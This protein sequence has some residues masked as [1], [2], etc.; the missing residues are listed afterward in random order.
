MNGSND[1]D[2]LRLEQV[3]H[4][5]CAFLASQVNETKW[6]LSVAREVA[7]ELETVPV[8]VPVSV[9]FST[10]LIGGA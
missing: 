7:Q 5:L 6:S 3:I 8:S 2:V 1:L 4:C 10:S 9:V